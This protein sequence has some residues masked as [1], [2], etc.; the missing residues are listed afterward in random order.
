MGEPSTVP[1]EPAVPVVGA[2]KTGEEPAY[3]R[4]LICCEVP[5]GSSHRESCPSRSAA[6]RP[7]VQCIGA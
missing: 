7:G 5:P 6:W 1:P 4:N 2:S 3:D